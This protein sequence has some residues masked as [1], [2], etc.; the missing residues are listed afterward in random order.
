MSPFLVAPFGS[1]GSVCRLGLASRGGTGLTEAGDFFPDLH[2]KKT[3]SP[4]R[5]WR[6]DTFS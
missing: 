2:F 3:H 6:N 4:K 5:I 1:L